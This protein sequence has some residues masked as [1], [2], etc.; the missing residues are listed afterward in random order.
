MKLLYLLLFINVLVKVST[1]NTLRL[2][3]VPQPNF[4]NKYQTS[5]AVGI[6]HIA[7]IIPCLLQCS[8]NVKCVSFFLSTSQQKCILHSKTF[9]DNPPSSSEDGWKFYIT[10]DV[11]G[12]CSPENGFV[13][14]RDLD[15]CYNLNNDADMGSL[16]NIKQTC[17]EVGSELIR[18]DSVDKQEYLMHVLEHYLLYNRKI[19]FIQGTNQHYTWPPIIWT[20]DDGTPMT[21]FNWDLGSSQPENKPFESMLAIGTSSGLWHDVP[22]YFAQNSIFLCERR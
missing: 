16:G 13:Y 4:D 11:T 2:K 17:A 10:E 20:F 9:W 7:K 15:I 18:I 8:R 6:D 12:R 19:I 21:Y 22:A 14:Y 1:Y 5:G 3:A